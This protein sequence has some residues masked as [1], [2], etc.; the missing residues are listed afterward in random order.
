MTGK[1]VMVWG[2][3]SDAGKSFL[4]AALCRY[5][6]DKG[7]RVAPFKAQNMSNNARV[8]RGGEMGCAQ[9]FQAK[10]A[11][12]V[13]EVRHNPVLLKPERDTRS[14]VVVMG[15]VD[16][17]L[18][19]MDWRGRSALLWERAR[20]A[21]LQL[22]SENDIVVIEGAGSPAEINLAESDYVNLMTARAANATCLLVSDIDRGGSFAHLY[23]TWAL[24]P[25]DLRT[26]LKGF[27]LNKLRADESLLEPGPTELFRR[28]GV[29]LVGVVPCVCHD[30]PDEDAVALDHFETADPA[31]ATHRVAL[32]AWPRISNFDE[33]RRLAAWPGVSLRLARRPSDLDGADL[34]ILPGSKNVPSDL[35]WLRAQGLD[36]AVTEFARSG[37]AL[38]GVCGG[39][40]SLGIRI[41]DPVGTEGNATGLGL[42]PLST[43]HGA[44][45]IVRDSS[46]S[47]PALD[48]FWTKLSGQTLSGYEIR[49]GA[50]AGLDP[51]SGE[52]RLACAGNVLGTYLHGAFEDPATL[53]A[54][55]GGDPASP[56]P[57]ERTLRDM[58]GLVE[59][60][61]DMD[62]V[63]SWLAATCAPPTESS[64]SG[65]LCVLT[66]GVRAGKSSAAQDKALAWGGQ[67]VSVI[68]TAQALD[69]EM[70][71]RIANHQA[72]RPTGWETIEEPLDI[73]SALR[74]ASHRTVVLDCANLWVT[75]LL[76]SEARVDFRQAVD[77]L[78]QAWRGS[79]KDLIV[80]TNEV[81]WG[82]VPDN[83]LSREFR[84]QLGW[85]NQR[86]VAASTEAWLY[87]SG[88]AL[89][90]K[91]AP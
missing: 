42:L 86:L 24:L 14:Q 85:A 44:T 18:S 27:V 20:P 78:I 68:A 45:K 66:G 69:D 40:Q 50:T 84:D 75:N 43:I 61:L 33:F 70:R 77:D 65:R 88:V 28:T 2:C 83:A 80:V 4:A 58:A 38:L 47:V 30:L 49:T 53:A 26:N 57:L 11:R 60:H 89:P 29:P 9:W 17:E 37:G 74:R 16:R 23:G 34:A 15:R 12:C 39:L 25:D 1:A 64:A 81:G 8:A 56:D 35:E 48:G 67:D 22:M 6:S 36:R 73:A 31:S 21:L 79:G 5:F 91:A 46:L 55:F 76:L 82:I 71:L 90:L 54:L 59:R 7:L 19:S 10:A 63:E 62:M 87:V 41:D 52:G 3:T 13:P 51:A 32:V 72:D